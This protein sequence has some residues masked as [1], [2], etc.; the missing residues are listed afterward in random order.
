M[1][2]LGRYVKYTQDPSRTSLGCNAANIHNVLDVSSQLFGVLTRPN[3]AVPDLPISVS[4]APGLDI[5]LLKENR[6]DLLHRERNQVGY[7]LTELL[8]D[9]V[10][11]GFADSISIVGVFRGFGTLCQD[12]RDNDDFWTSIAVWKCRHRLDWT[13]VSFPSNRPRRSM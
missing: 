9:K 3:W 1:S 11:C 12:R 6:G 13:T 10:H 7:F 4:T 8:G 2:R 5:S